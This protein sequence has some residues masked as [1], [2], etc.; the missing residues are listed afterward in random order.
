V[1]RADVEA[2]AEQLGRVLAAVEAGE[3][4]ASAGMRQRL[5][6]AVSALQIVLG[7]Q[8]D[9]VVEA[10]LQHAGDAGTGSTRSRRGTS[11]ESPS[12]AVPE[13]SDE[14]SPLDQ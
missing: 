10:L 9:D 5:V 11:V 2:L 4:D 12:H 1:K 6:G 8:P 7:E 13:P 3:L 14:D